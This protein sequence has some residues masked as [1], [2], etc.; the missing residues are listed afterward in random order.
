LQRVSPLPEQVQRKHGVPRE[1]K[2]ACTRPWPKEQNTRN[3]LF[4]GSKASKSTCSQGMLRRRHECRRSCTWT[5]RELTTQQRGARSEMHL[6]RCRQNSCKL[7]APHA[8]SGQRCRPTCSSDGNECSQALEPRERPCLSV[9]LPIEE[10][11]ERNGQSP[12]THL[13]LRILR[14]SAEFSIRRQ[15]S[16]S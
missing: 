1:H 9:V 13:R 14:T 7:D 3:L 8:R 6:A 12:G 11:D 15:F 10:Q 16:S 2:Q 4:Q 5:R